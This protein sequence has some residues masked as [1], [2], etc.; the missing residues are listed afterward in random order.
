MMQ[1][2]RRV[3]VSAGADANLLVWELATERSAGPR[4]TT[5]PHPRANVLMRT[6]LEVPASDLDGSG[7]LIK[8][9]PKLPE[10]AIKPIK[11]GLMPRSAT[12]IGFDCTGGCCLEW[13]RSRG[14]LAHIAGGGALLSRLDDSSQVQLVPP[15]SAGA[16]HALAASIDGAA[17]ATAHAPACS[18]A[19][20][21]ESC[22]AHMCVW[23]LDGGPPAPCLALML[24]SPLVHTEALAFSPDGCFLAAAGGGRLVLW[25][26]LEAAG[27]ML[28]M[29]IAPQVRA[30][31]HLVMVPHRAHAHIYGG[32]GSKVDMRCC[33]C[34]LSLTRKFQTI[35]ARS[36]LHAC[37]M[38]CTVHVAPGLAAMAIVAHATER[39]TGR[40]AH[41]DAGT[42]VS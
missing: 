13:L 15:A 28:G 42:V 24:P 5:R 32:V 40:A 3:L 23:R 1:G 33:L 16:A 17:L 12:L 9:S 31:H 7:C 11:S 25:E 2:F 30:Q 36:C 14:A 37:V 21:A 10:A 41:V 39:W 19:T 35:A 20:G 38:P 34:A 8:S 22:S 6:W 29:G 27:R 18:T 26:V 4:N